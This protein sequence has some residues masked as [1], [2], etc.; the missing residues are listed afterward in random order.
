MRPSNALRSN[1]TIFMIMFAVAAL[2]VQPAVSD[3]QHQAGVG[4]PPGPPLRQHSFSTL[5]RSRPLHPGHP[6]HL[7]RPTF[8]RISA[9]HFL[10]QTPPGPPTKPS[11]PSSNPTSGAT[12]CDFV[13]QTF[14]AL[15][16]LP[17]V[18]SASLSRNIRATSSRALLPR[19]RSAGRSR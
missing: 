18:R 4:S 17:S 5:R 13:S 19:S 1:T 9:S 7:P 12:R 8:N 16:R 14:S 6:R 3:D 11:A 10:T 15:N 2:A